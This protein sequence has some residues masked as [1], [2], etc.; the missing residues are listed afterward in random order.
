MERANGQRRLP[1]VGCHGRDIRF[2]KYRQERI[3]RK[4]ILES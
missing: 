4:E 3:K 1:T 2:Q